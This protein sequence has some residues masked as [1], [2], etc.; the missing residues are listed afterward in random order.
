ML[1]YSSK[2]VLFVTI[3]MT[4]RGAHE[5]RN[6]LLNLQGHYE[7]AISGKNVSRENES[8][9]VMSFLWEQSLI[10]KRALQNEYYLKYDSLL[11][12][13]HTGF[14]LTCKLSVNSNLPNSIHV[15]ES[16]SKSIRLSQTKTRQ[17]TCNMGRYTT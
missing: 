12:S 9:Q 5:I 4:Y 11:L 15:I 17:C 10:L 7:Q 8:P 1:R 2:E 13:I 6:V 16:E 14:A 3:G